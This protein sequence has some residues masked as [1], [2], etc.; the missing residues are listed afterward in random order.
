MD[1]GLSGRRALVLAST[2]GLGQ[3]IAR[4]LATEG[5]VV[6]VS[7]R[8]VGRC[9]GAAAELPGGIAVPGDLSV[10]GTAAQVVATAA[11]ALG[12][13]DVL[14]VNTGGGRPGGMLDVTEADEVAGFDSMLRPALSAVRAAVPFLRA[15]AAGRLLFVTARSVLEASP[16][17]ALSGVFRSGVAAAARSL[18]L[19]LA[20][21]VNVNV[22]VPGQFDT[23]ALHRFEAALVK[24]QGRTA[25]QV[26]QHHVGLIPLRRVGRPEELADLAVFLAG[27]RASYV[28]GSVFRVDGGAVRG[29]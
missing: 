7:G 25:D 5:A 19:E 29:Y 1:M 13:L 9:R 4:G 8:D 3:A 26:R 11:E 16:D 12:G 24:Q 27:D 20:P 28:T 22:L 10:P 14:V 6:A 18:A 21:S 17:L 2:A 23:G 15:S